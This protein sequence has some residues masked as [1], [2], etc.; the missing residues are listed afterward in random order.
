MQL[1]KKLALLVLGAFLV[2]AMAEHRRAMWGW[3][4][5]DIQQK[6]GR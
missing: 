3:M 2:Y 5:D 1:I 4:V 6:V